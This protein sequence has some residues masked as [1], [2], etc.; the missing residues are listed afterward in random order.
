MFPSLT[1]VNN[2]TTPRQRLKPKHTQKTKQHHLHQ[3]K[4]T[5]AAQNYILTSL[6][7]VVS[8][9]KSATKTRDTKRV[10]QFY[11]SRPKSDEPTIFKLYWQEH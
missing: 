8:I 3:Q 7:L 6:S 5:K 1:S 4:K 11:V 10:T 2:Y 9:A